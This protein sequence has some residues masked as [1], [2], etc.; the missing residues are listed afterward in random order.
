VEDI[1]EWLRPPTPAR[2]EPMP[3]TEA[4]WNKRAQM[5][6]ELILEMK[7]EI[8]KL[9]SQVNDLRQKLK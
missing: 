1:D 5:D 9:K 6:Q 7:D 8:S 2:G 3:Q 4:Y